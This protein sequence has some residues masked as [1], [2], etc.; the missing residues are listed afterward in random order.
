MKAIENYHRLTG[1]A[2]RKADIYL[3]NIPKEE[4][5]EVKEK[6]KK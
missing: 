3:G 5:E 1:E 4:V 6:K 2:K